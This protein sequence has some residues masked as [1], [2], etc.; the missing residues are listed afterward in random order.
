MTLYKR[1]KESYA[2]G[3]VGDNAKCVTGIGILLSYQQLAHSLSLS[4]P[5][6]TTESCLTW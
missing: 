5:L 2:R 1:A 3:D 4:P 6:D